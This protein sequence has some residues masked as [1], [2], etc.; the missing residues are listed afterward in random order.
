MPLLKPLPSVPSSGYA[1]LF[2]SASGV[3]AAAV[4]NLAQAASKHQSAG[5]AAFRA[6]AAPNITSSGHS[7]TELQHGEVRRL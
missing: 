1:K 6:S 5:A 2:G 4:P 3:E 7:D